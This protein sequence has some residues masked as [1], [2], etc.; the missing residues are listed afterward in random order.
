M[1]V[2]QAGTLATLQAHPAWAVTSTLPDPPSAP[3]AALPAE[4][5]LLQLTV[6]VATALVT[7]PPAFVTTTE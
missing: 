5:E 2:T 3:N 4:S 7:A 6:N 1:I